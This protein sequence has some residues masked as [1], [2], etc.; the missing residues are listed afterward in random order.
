MSTFDE[1]G[2][3]FQKN[4]LAIKDLPSGNGSKNTLKPMLELLHFMDL[5]TLVKLKEIGG[6]SKFDTIET[7]DLLKSETQI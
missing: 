1:E 7:Y 2:Y 5:L 4:L 6:K 3:F